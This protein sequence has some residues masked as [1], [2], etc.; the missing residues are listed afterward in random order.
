M[1]LTKNIVNRPLAGA[2]VDAIGECDHQF[3][4]KGGVILEKYG[5]YRFIKLTNSHEGTAVAYGLYEADRNQFGEKVIPLMSDGWKLFSS[6][7]THPQFPAVP[8]SLDLA[9][10][11]QGFKHN[12]IFSCT[13]KQCTVS[14][15]FGE[16][17]KIKYIHLTTLLELSI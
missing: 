8:S 1:Q 9:K 17:L 7:H 2:I 3:E 16:E 5:D 11:F 13:D 4:E 14:E 15:W 10:L 12:V 6:F